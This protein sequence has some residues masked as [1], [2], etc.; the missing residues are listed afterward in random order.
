MGIG[1]RKLALVGAALVAGGLAVA[2]DAFAQ[3][4]GPTTQSYPT[5]RP[6]GQGRPPVAGQPGVR[7]P[8]ARPNPGYPGRPPGQW[9]RPPQNNW[10][11]PR[12]H[13][14]PP[15]YRPG[16]RCTVQYRIVPSPYGPVRKPFRVC[17]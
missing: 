17:Y 13:Y 16:P 1:L 11:P 9:Q 12:P 15:M 8:I 10:G 7:P 5:T 2:G 6:L 4:G 3:Y 14:R